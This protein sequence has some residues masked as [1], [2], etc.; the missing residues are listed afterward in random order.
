MTLH[1]KLKY[2]PMETDVIVYLDGTSY[3]FDRDYDK[4]YVVL[5]VQ[6]S[7][8]HPALKAK[9]IAHVRQDLIQDLCYVCR[10]PDKK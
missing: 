7:S 4:H 2:Y 1:E 10:K 3:R 6:G 8:R 5:V 9:P